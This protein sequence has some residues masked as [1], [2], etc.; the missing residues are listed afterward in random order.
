MAHDLDA[1]K[2]EIESQLEANGIVIFYGCSRAINDSHTVHWDVDRHPDY[3][4]FVKAARQASVKMMVLHHREFG[5]GSVD[6]ALERLEET[7]MSM[8]DRRVFERRLRDLR[9]Y[10]GFT[11]ALELSFDYQERV[12][13]FELRT[14][15]YLE[16][17]DALEEIDVYY[18]GDD[19]DDDE[20]SI[21]GYYSRN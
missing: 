10:E 13:L 19:D 6:D 15:W 1:L 9:M 2:T 12:Y 7:D 3:N 14:E 21:G 4:D 20:D 18:P 8:D 17:L 5:A 11:C 16:F